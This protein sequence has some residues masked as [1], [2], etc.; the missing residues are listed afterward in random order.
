MSGLIQKPVQYVVTTVEE[1]LDVPLKVVEKA[2]VGPLL[3]VSASLWLTI[4]LIL[5]FVL[6]VLAD[7]KSSPLTCRDDGKICFKILKGT[8]GVAG[9]GGALTLVTLGLI[10]FF[11]VVVFKLV[12]RGVQEHG[13]KPV[14]FVTIASLF[15][16]AE[17]FKVF[18]EDINQI[19][20][21][22]DNVFSGSTTTG[23][24]FQKICQRFLFS[25][26]ELFRVTGTPFDTDGGAGQI[27]KITSTAVVIVLGVAAG[28]LARK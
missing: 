23:E 5:L 6:Y 17:F 10:I 21:T 12:A 8:P 9:R 28:S 14:A 11:L 16:V 3:N 26:I 27:F 20:L 22:D 2:V 13:I 7:W 25:V 1:V 19:A 15:G 18:F 4:S 24:S